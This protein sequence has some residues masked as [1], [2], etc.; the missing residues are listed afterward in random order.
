MDIQER[1]QAY[2]VNMTMISG[3]SQNNVKTTWY[4]VQINSSELPKTYG[5]ISRN[6]KCPWNWNS[7]TTSHCDAI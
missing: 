7:S 6:S 4:E 3:I 5:F 1:K 2:I